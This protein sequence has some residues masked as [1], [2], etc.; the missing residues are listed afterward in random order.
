MGCMAIVVMK[1]ATMKT[2][3]TEKRK[4]NGS[5]W[6]NPVT[7]K[8][9][10][11]RDNHTCVYCNRSIYTNSNLVLSIDHVTPVELGGDNSHSNLVTCCKRCNS[12]KRH[13]NLAKFLQF[14]TDNGVNT[15]GIKKRVRNARRRKLPKTER[16]KV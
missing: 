7:R 11:L 14:L 12:R 4:W 9:L 10:Y 1:G 15:K 2:G 5:K 6:L 16:T 3:K 13:L 8:R